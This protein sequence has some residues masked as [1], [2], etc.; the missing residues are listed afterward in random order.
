VEGIGFIIL[1]FVVGIALLVLEVF[2]PSHG[3]LTVASVMVLVWGVARTY[4]VSSTAG[5][6]VG[7]A[8]L[9][10]VPLLMYGGI[11]IWPHTAIGRRI[12]PPNRVLDDTS[13]MHK[14]ELS[15]L[16]GME[17]RSLSPLRPVGTCEFDGRRV[18]CRSEMGMI[19]T[20]RSVRAVAVEGPDLI[21]E[22][23]GIANSSMT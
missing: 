13:M 8:C 11:R 18:V 14:Q 10:I 9:I 1:L 19:E 5:G 22:E 20:G 6:V 7:I 2:I 4:A 16:V 17:G 3:L 12:A 15:P 21:V 23:I